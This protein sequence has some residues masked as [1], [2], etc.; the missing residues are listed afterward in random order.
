MIKG[1]GDLKPTAEMIEAKAIILFYQDELQNLEWIAAN[2]AKGN[3]RI[4]DEVG[5]ELDR[6]EKHPDHVQERFRKRARQALGA[7][8]G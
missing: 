5:R 4:G 6:W 2:D 1:K 8:D 7:A 3:T